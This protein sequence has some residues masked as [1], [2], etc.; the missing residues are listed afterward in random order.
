M[1]EM[2]DTKA[3]LGASITEAHPGFLARVPVRLRRSVRRFRERQREQ[4]AAV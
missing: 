3:P 2:T 1:I 4:R